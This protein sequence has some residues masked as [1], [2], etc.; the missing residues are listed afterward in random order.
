MMEPIDVLRKYWNYSR[1]RPLQEEIIH[2]VLAAAPTLALLPTGGGKSICFQVP[3]LMLDGICLVVTPLIAL[4]RDQVNQLRQRG[5]PAS[6]LYSG[7]HAREID[8]VLDNCAHGGVKLLY[9]SPERL[10]TPLFQERMSRTEIA[11]LV[12]DEAHCISEWGH[13]F[14]PAYR[15]LGEFLALFSIDRKLALTATATP[16]V[17]KDIT[18]QLQMPTAA[19]FEGSYARLN[20]S[21]SAFE[22]ED[23][24]AKLLEILHQVPGSSI[25]YAGTR[26]QCES[27]AQWLVRKGISADFYHAGL[28]SKTRQDREKAWLT[29]QTR[30]MVAT[31]AFGMGIDKPN[32]RTVIHAH[33]PSSLEALYQ[34]AGRA[35]RD[36]KIAYA[37]CIFSSIEWAQAEKRLQERQPSIADMHRVYDGFCNSHKVAVGSHALSRLPL[38][39][40]VLVDQYNFK[41]REVL[42]SMRALQDAGIL[43]LSDR[44]DEP[45]RCHITVSPADLYAFQVANKRLD[46]IIKS[47]LRLYGGQLYSEY[48]P[49]QLQVLARMSELN[50]EE[51]N[52]QLN[53]LSNNGWIDL[54]RPTDEATVLLLAP[55]MPAQRLPIDTRQLRQHH[56][57]ALDK[58]RQVGKYL[59]NHAKCRTRQFQEYFGEQGHQDCGVCDYCLRYKKQTKAPVDE[60]EILAYIQSASRSIPEVLTYLKEYDP[61]VVKDTL[62]WLLDA[63][64][65]QMKDERLLVPD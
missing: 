14:R 47:L 63:G 3:A 60:N 39:L 65:I 11:M 7:M 35:G 19:I 15:Q 5:I 21:Y 56:E 33:V 13:D 41:A 55:R 20:L 23:K 1:F 40:D 37:V 31:N 48:V 43:E 18:M 58:L 17:K 61:E 9:V 54:Q 2:S 44:Y 57:Q 45:T 52:Q 29:D 59:G 25:V 24:D 8:I 50:L 46:P 34:E 64:K 51:L 62:R 32:V 4:M 36:G 53:Y 12:V 38:R 49:I 42:L 28:N 26:N 22:L 10:H 6:A 30:V 16:E 27:Y